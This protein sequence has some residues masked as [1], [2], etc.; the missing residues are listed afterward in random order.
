MISGKRANVMDAYILP[1]KKK[2]TID[3]VIYLK[4]IENLIKVVKKT[5]G[6]TI[7]QI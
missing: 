3:A 2:I 5:F 1:Y 4:K 7:E 6:H